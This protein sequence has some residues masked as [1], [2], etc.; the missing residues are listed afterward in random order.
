MGR[1]LREERKRQALWRS[2][3][4]WL[5]Q[6]ARNGEGF[7]S[8]TGGGPYDFC[9]PQ[10]LAHENL[11]EDIR[12]GALNYFENPPGPLGG[13]APIPWHDGGS[14]LPSTH[15]CDSQVC[16]V[17]FLFPFR[18]NE[19]AATALLRLAF[20]DCF[21]AVPVQ[22]DTEGL[23]EFEWLGDPAIDLLGEGSPRQRGAHATSMDVAMCF[24]DRGRKR[25]LVLIEWK[26]TESYRRSELLGAGKFGNSPDGAKRRIRYEHLF[27]APDSPIDHG[28]VTFDELGFEPFYQFLRQQLLA[29]ALEP[30]FSTARV[31]HIAPRGNVDFAL[32]TPERLRRENPN[33]S[34]TNVWFGLLRVPGRFASAHTEDLFGPLINSPPAGLE[35][36]AEYLRDRYPSILSS[37]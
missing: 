30:E 3:T 35:R 21:C 24:C 11:F 5:T 19:A 22:P 17:N 4:R 25:H 18:F 23:V 1:F 8:K 34:A 36:W 13:S 28:R 16:C 10:Q 2:K 15:L 20:D 14:R 6:R 31:L 27:S 37:T 26:Y 9:L 7:Y 29:Q 32:V 33:S 12:R